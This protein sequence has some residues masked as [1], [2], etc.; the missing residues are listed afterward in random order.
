MVARYRLA[1]SQ[2]PSGIVNKEICP[3]HDLSWSPHVNMHAGPGK[4]KQHVKS[5][6][7]LHA[8]AG[9]LADRCK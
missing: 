4:T 9:N 8:S 3:D 1:F 6:I 5:D 2:A 7:M